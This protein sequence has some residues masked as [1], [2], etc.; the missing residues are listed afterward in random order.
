MAR[1]KVTPR[2]G[3]RGESRWVRTR[4]EVH[5]QPQKPSTSV[6]PPIPTHRTPLDWEEMRRRI[7][8]AEQLEE[9]GRLPESSPTQQLAQMAAETGPSMSGQK[10]PARRKLQLTVGGKAPPQGIP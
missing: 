10:E 3:E 2:K 8:E 6:G 5:T 1:T 7:T 4:V 9:V